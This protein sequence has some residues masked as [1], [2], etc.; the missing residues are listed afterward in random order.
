M[1]EFKCSCGK[2]LIIADKFFRTEENNAIV[3]KCVGCYCNN[4]KA[5]IL[6]WSGCGSKKS[7]SILVFYL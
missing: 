5:S 2:E 4:D 1:E 3:Y 6:K 7:G